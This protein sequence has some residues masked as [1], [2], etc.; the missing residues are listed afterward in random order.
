M[1][2]L[3]IAM[4][5]GLAIVAAS[6][7]WA[8]ESAG[9]TENSADSQRADS[10]REIAEAAGKNWVKQ[11]AQDMQLSANP[12]ART[13][14]E[15]ALQ[16]LAESSGDQSKSSM[17]RLNEEHK[18][19]LYSAKTSVPIR[20]LL[21]QAACAGH[22]N[23]EPLC[24]DAKLVD[25]LIADD[26]K[27]AYTVLYA[28]SLRAGAATRALERTPTSNGA[29]IPDSKYADLA[30]ALEFHSSARVLKALA[31]VSEYYDYAQAFKA[32]VLLAVKR[33]P[34]PTEV[35]ASFPIEVAALAA[36]FAPEEIA[37][38]VV[39]NGLI[40]ATESTYR[41]MSACALPES[42]ELTKQCARVANLIL[43]NPKNSA[44]SAGFA[45]RGAKD[46]AFAKRMS[47][48]HD[49]ANQKAVDPMILLT[50]DW[51]ALRSV[52]NK[53]A[54]QG[55]VAAIPDALAW[56]ELA[57]AKIPN[58]PSEVI[59]A[60][61]KER[62]AHQ[63]KWQAE[64]ERAQSTEAAEAA[65]AVQAASEATAA[66]AGIEVQLEFDAVPPPPA[67][68][69]GGCSPDEDEKIDPTVV[70]FKN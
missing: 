56:A 59:A 4:S 69:S 39:A 37:A 61:L 70:E 28:E 32:P 18:R 21:L 58:K 27:N 6:A 57:Y 67:K 2:K 8:G 7:G 19:A 15:L 40:I 64:R 60:E 14:A 3:F 47:A 26:A 20:I 68:S 12:L 24:D 46:H 34:P 29:K 52:L 42:V 38:E 53:A 35:L 9:K 25:A 44:A 23:Q 1:K 31:V 63:A 13:M 48:F 49:I 41:Q 55:D 66:S 62:E 16:S 50:L 30:K 22:Y 54:T 10:Q 43:A 51:L 33:R 17:G 65:A 5:L 45:L 36:A 11:L